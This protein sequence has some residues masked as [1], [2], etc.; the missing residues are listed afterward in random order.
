MNTC[1]FCFSFGNT[2][3]LCMEAETCGIQN[4]YLP[5]MHKHNVCNRCK[6]TYNNY[7]TSSKN[8]VKNINTKNNKIAK[9][10]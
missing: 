10:N 2:T 9:I 5:F 3:V 6:T 7:A 8:N 4:C 1:Q